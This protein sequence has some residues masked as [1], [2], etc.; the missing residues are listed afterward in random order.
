MRRLLSCVIFRPGRKTSITFLITGKYLSI[1]EKY[2][3]II[4]W[5]NG[6]NHAGN[7]GNFNLIHFVTLRGMV[8]TE[9]NNSFAEIEIYRNKIWIK[10]SGREKSQ[11][12]AL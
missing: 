10:G 7:Y 11:I 1:L 4:A 9:A 5:F 3:N 12:L 6:H 2:S 8:E